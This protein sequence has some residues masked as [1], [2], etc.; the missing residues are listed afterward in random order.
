MIVF[1]LAQISIRSMPSSIACQA[2]LEDIE[3]RKHF[4]RQPEP[5]EAPGQ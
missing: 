2:D 4:G 1:L 5:R 3:Q